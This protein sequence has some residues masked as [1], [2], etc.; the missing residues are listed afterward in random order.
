MQA[1]FESEVWAL[2]NMTIGDTPI[3]NAL[4]VAVEA[5]LYCHQ[6][7]DLFRRCGG[8]YGTPEQVFDKYPKAHLLYAPQA[9]I[10]A[11]R[12]DFAFYQ[13]EEM[14]GTRALIVECD[15]HDFHER[16][17]EQAL[18]D[19]SRDRRLQELGYTVYRFTGSE[20]Y[21]DPMKCAE[22]ILRWADAQ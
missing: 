4:F 3:E 15:G 9:Q 13:R 17:K 7:T 22:Q 18:A 5:W 10:E 20:I 6:M 8:N 2:L 19:R 12:V 1:Q 14:G 21:T 11:Y 16:T